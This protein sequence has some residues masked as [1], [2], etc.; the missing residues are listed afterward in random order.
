[1]V[2]R[3]CP[4]CRFGNAVDSRYCNKCGAPLEWLV[5]D[6]PE[7]STALMVAGRALPVRWKQIG[8]TVAIGAA[9]L[10]AEAGLS[11]LRRRIEGGTTTQ[12]ARTPEAQAPAE[13]AQTQ[14]GHRKITT[15]L[16]QRVIE[17]SDDADGTRR[18]ND[19]QVWRKV[20]E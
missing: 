18:V 2:E 17:V 4:A 5:R 1:M 10:A 8:T 15:I 9:A 19:R 13:Q 12:L 16:S 6:K 20:E 11:W 3:I 7:P 14:L